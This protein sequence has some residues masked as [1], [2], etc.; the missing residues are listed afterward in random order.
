RVVLDRL[1]DL[2][3][4]A[5]VRFASVYK[6]FQGAADFEKEVAALESAEQPG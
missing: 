6:E 5:Y 2:D 4:V 3:E 1:R